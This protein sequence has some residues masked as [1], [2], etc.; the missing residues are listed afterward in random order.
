MSMPASKT[1]CSAS[2]K[3]YVDHINPFTGLAYKDDPAIVTML[4]TNEN[5]ATFHYGNNLLPDK[6][7]PWHDGLYM[8]Q[9]EAFAEKYGLPKS[10]VWKSWLPGPSKLFLNDLE[11]QFDDKMIQQLRT[12]GVKSPIVTTSTFGGNP[13]SSLPA[14]T[15]GDMIDAHSYGSTENWKKTQYMDRIS[16]TGSRRRTLSI[17]R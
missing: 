1:R 5:D 2:I 10:E 7:V 15:A 14:L 8:A 6:N 4:L 9:A 13:L 12:L 11:H 17:D 3:T 16:W